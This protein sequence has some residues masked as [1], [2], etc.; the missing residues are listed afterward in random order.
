MYVDM[1]RVRVVSR[2]YRPRNLT[3]LSN[4]NPT[5]TLGKARYPCN[6][7]APR[8]LG[9]ANVL[10]TSSRIGYDPSPFHHRFHYESAISGRPS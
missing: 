6:E 2:P 1:P 3:G 4:Q 9:S 7:H 8:I 5:S 10:A